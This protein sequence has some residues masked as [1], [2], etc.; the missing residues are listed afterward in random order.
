MTTVWWTSR[1]MRAAAVALLVAAWPACNSHVEPPGP[2]LDYVLQDMHGD[3]VS[4]S[5][6][7]GKPLLINFWATWCGPCKLEIPWFVEFTDEYKDQGLTIVGISLDDPVEEIRA[8]AEEYKVNYPMLV[9]KGREEVAREFGAEA[10]L[11]VTWLI[12]P[13]GSVQAHAVGIHDRKWF[14]TQIEAMF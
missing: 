5:E 3:E 6:F 7:G 11:P 9:G 1:W 10:V 2:S 8:F 13:D 12:R 4:L 14:E